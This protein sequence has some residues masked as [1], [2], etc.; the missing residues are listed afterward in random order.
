MKKLRGNIATEILFF[1]IHGVNVN[2]LRC[3]FHL[4]GGSLSTLSVP[5]VGFFPAYSGNAGPYRNNPDAADIKNVGPLPPGRYFIVNRPTTLLSPVYDAPKSF[6]SGSDRSLWFGLFRDDG[7]IDD[8][9]LY[10]NV[11]RGSFRLHPAGYQGISNGCITLASRCHY[12]ILRNALLSE[13]N[14]KIRIQSLIAYGTVQV[15]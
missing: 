13:H 11:Q 10:K 3:L 15:Y 8:V 2:M 4:N 14:A 7:S 1:L 6:F 9:T 12:E 5:G